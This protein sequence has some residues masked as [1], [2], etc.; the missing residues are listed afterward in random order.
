MTTS[1]ALL[2]L[3]KASHP[4][5]SVAVTTVTALL[6]NAVGHDLRS[7]L[8]VTT[9]VAAGQLSIGWSNDLIDVDRDRQVGRE[10]KPVARGEVTPALVNAAVAAALL[11]CVLLSLA[12]GFASAAVHL[13][14]GVAS[15]WAY[16]LGMKRLIW[17]AVPYAV[18]FGALPAVVTLALP[19]PRLPP[20]WLAMTGA[21]LGVGAHLLNALPDLVD[22]AHTGIRGLPHRLGERGVRLLAPV[23]LLGASAG[24][25]LG[26]SGTPPL[27]A[28]AALVGC[29]V[30]AVV[31][32]TG[33]GRVPFSAAVG[34]ALVD[35]VSL[36]VRS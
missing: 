19:A 29:L 9:A 27:A 20:A 11:V 28:W 16:N 23:V 17:S 7:G 12:C 5:P 14:L 15:G 35:V 22:D 24:A 33:R 31:A 6:S 36:V 18:A 32:M 30:L 1:A 3:A 21:L 13:G 34:I 26:P 4:G 2:G 10:D 8:L 25:V